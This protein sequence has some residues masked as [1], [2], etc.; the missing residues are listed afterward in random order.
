MRV[1]NIRSRRRGVVH[2]AGQIRLLRCGTGTNVYDLDHPKSRSY[3]ATGDPLTCHVCLKMP[4]KR[5]QVPLNGCRYC[6][7]HADIHPQQTNH[8][9]EVP[10]ELQTLVR[11]AVLFGEGEVEEIPPHLCN[12][13]VRITGTDAV[14]KSVVINGKLAVVKVH[15]F[16][17]DHTCSLCG[18]VGRRDVLEQEEE[19][20]SL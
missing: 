2:T 7:E 13:A 1:P 15:V 10:T 4:A 11:S 3:E 14:P 16:F 5:D 18:N 20:W 8:Y 9:Y 6:G 19:R 17:Q 12:Q